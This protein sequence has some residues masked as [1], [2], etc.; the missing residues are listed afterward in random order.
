LEKSPTDVA[1]LAEEMW[2]QIV[3]AN[4]Q[5]INIALDIRRDEDFPKRIKVD[6]VRLGQVLWNLLENSRSACDCDKGKIVVWLKTD[7]KQN[8]VRIEVH[9]NG[10]GI[11]PQVLPNIFEPFFTT[12][13]KGTGLGLAICRRIV[14][15][16]GGELKVTCGET[17]CFA[18]SLPADVRVGSPTESST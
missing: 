9:D 11:D 18:I 3:S 12:K 7:T 5:A 2:R 17:T 13:T 16:F 15:A 10:P 14:D 6:R 8:Q 4:P 1:T